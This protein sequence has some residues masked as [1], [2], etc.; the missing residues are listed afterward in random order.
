MD[1]QATGRWSAV[2]ESHC[3]GDEMEATL[4]LV[5]SE[6]LGAREL[7]VTRTLSFQGRGMQEENGLSSEGETF[8]FELL[9]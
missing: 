5:R 7:S 9:H 3:T 6:G 4:W 8:H 2:T 1:R